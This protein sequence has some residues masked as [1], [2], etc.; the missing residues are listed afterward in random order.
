MSQGDGRP[1]H[2]GRNLVEENQATPA[3]GSASQG[4]KS[5]QLGMLGQPSVSVQ[6]SFSWVGKFHLSEV[7]LV[8]TQKNNVKRQILFVAQWFPVVTKEALFVV[9]FKGKVHW[10]P[11]PVK[12][13]KQQTPAAGKPDVPPQK[14]RDPSAL[15]ELWQPPPQ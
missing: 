11:A 15:L 8:F 7:L 14:E 9:K 3:T 12:P 10:L 13:S 1:C 4:R 6:D 5:G 2:K